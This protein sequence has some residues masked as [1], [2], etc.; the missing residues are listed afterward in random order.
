[1]YLL[2]H[3]LIE[4]SQRRNLLN[5]L[6]HSELSAPEADEV[7]LSVFVLSIGCYLFVQ[8]PHAVR[9]DNIYSFTHPPQ[10]ARMNSIMQTVQTW[11]ALRRPSLTPWVTQANFNRCM[12]AV[13]DAT[14]DITGGWNWERQTAFFG[15]EDGARYFRSL[16]EAS[17]SLQPR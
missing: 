7:L 15:S 5:M 2:L 11:C 6:R 9:A 10:A 3:H 17:A 14:L 16:S 4:S 1:M 13:A 12:A 8:T